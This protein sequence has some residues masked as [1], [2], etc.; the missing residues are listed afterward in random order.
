MVTMN[1]NGQTH[2]VPVGTDDTVVDVLRDRLH[3]TGTKLVCGGGVCGA[4][5]VLLDGEPVASCLLPAAA[6]DGR[7]VE[8]VEGVAARA[9]PVVRAF[10]ACDALQCGFCTPGFVVEA[11]SFHDRWR[12]EHGRA[13]PNDAT[14]AQRS[15]GTSVGVRRIRRS[16]K[17]YAGPALAG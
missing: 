5:T 1:V 2:D 13:E 14:I 11:A 9:H 7:A 15:P 6:V 3:L 16:T 8:T 4:C 10:A 17:Q 12:V